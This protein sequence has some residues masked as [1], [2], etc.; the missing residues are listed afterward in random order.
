MRLKLICAVLVGV[1]LIAPGCGSKKK[2]AATTP[3]GANTIN[4]VVNGGLEVNTVGWSTAA[5]NTVV[6]STAHAKSGHA[7]GLA[8]RNTQTPDTDVANFHMTL[9]AGKTYNLSYWIF[10]PPD[11]SGTGIG[12]NA[13][14]IGGSAVSGGKVGLAIRGQWQ[15][16]ET[17]FKLGATT[18]GYLVLRM[19]GAK[20]GD[21][22]YIDDVRVSPVA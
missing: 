6:R 21:R 7:S 9:E 12:L 3:E 10:I 1:L 19:P 22:A 17:A 16:V 18:G 14:W 11:Y 20:T 8:T 15:H 5:P 4:L 2:S 13:E